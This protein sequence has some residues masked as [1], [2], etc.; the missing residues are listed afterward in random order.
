[1]W[2]VTLWPAGRGLGGSGLI[3][4]MIYIRGSVQGFDDVAER[5]SN[6][7]WTMRNAQKHYKQLEDYHG[8]FD[9]SE[10]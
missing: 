1:M 9:Q 10:N 5:T 6:P 8:H 3:N 2:Q 7:I 4:G